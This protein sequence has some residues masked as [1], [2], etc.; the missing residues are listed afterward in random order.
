M[1]PHFHVRQ[2]YV[3]CL[4]QSVVNKMMN[5]GDTELMERG[6]HCIT[7]L[8]EGGGRVGRRDGREGEEGRG[9]GGGGGEVGRRVT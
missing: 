1:C 2:A 6:F 8:V 4:E 9:R 5:K 3:K 7:W